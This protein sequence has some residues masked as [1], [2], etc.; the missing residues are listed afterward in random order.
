MEITLG[1]EGNHEK[2][3]YTLGLEIERKKK[4]RKAELGQEGWGPQL[5]GRK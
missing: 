3:Q 4:K 5:G 1:G 2:V